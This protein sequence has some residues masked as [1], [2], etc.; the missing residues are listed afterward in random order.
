MKVPHIASAC[1]LTVLMTTLPAMARISVT[2]SG[3]NYLVNNG[4][5]CVAVFD[6]HGKEKSS[7]KTCSRNDLRDMEDAVDDYRD[8]DYRDDRYSDSDRDRY[9]SSHSS[10]HHGGRGDYEIHG[11]SDNKLRIWDRPSKHSSVVAGGVH[12]GERVRGLGNCEHHDGDQW[13]EVEYRGDRG[14]VMQKFLRETSSSS[15]HHSSSHHRDDDRKEFSD[16][17]GARASSADS[18]LR[19]RGFSHVDTFK[20]GYT[21]YSIWYNRHT[22]QCLQMA[23]ADGRADS[24]VDIHQH[25][26]C[27]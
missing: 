22:R 19:D 26:K 2:Q 14:W 3:E 5:G 6:R 25:D 17:Q 9:S 18:E 10:S 15:S 21:S 12:N 27:R 16:L 24:I 8:G 11:V 13:C 23:I 20:S 1:A 4:D 7:T